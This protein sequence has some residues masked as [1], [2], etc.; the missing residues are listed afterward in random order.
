VLTGPK[1]KT[2]QCRLV[3]VSDNL[4]E[5]LNPRRKTTSAI[6]LER[7]IDVFSERTHELAMKV[8]TI[9]WPHNAIRHSFGSCFPGKSKNVKIRQLPESGGLYT[10]QIQ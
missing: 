6:S 2:R 3:S 1:A 8:E 10:S 9:P 5:W 4:L 7:N